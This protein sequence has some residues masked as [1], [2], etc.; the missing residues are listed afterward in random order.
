MCFI[1]CLAAP[2]LVSF[3]VKQ[4]DTADARDLQDDKDRENQGH[5]LPALQNRQGD[6]HDANPQGKLAEV[7]RVA[8]SGPEAGV[9]EFDLVLRIGN[10]SSLLVISRDFYDKSIGPYQEAHRG[11]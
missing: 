10:E 4:W 9:D 11:E 3:L 1:I 6:D 2:F 8:G 5:P 7:V